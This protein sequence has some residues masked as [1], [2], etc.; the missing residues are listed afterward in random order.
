MLSSSNLLPLPLTSTLT[1]NKFNKFVNGSVAC[2][3]YPMFDALA[4]CGTSIWLSVSLRNAAEHTSSN[5]SIFLLAACLIILAGLSTTGVSLWLYKRYCSWSARH[6][7]SSNSAWA[8]FREIA[9]GCRK[10]CGAFA[11]L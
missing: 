8:L 11:E 7:S 3:V 1:L 6:V 5:L 4:K 2:K 10:R 9:V